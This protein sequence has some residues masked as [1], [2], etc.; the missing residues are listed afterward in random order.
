MEANEK[1]ITIPPLP[2]DGHPAPDHALPG[3]PPHCRVPARHDQRGPDRA[4]P[5]GPSRSARPYV[6]V[7]TSQRRRSGLG[8]QVIGDLPGHPQRERADRRPLSEPARPGADR[9]ITSRQARGA[10]AVSVTP[11]G[12]VMAVS[13]CS[14]G[15]IPGSEETRLNPV[16]CAMLTH[17]TTPWPRPSGQDQ[18]R[19]GPGTART[20]WPGLV[21]PGSAAR[22]TS[23]VTAAM[24]VTTLPSWR[25]GGARR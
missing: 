8:Q 15:Q 4:L 10:Y 12:R 25:A 21:R 19:P 6:P 2:R 22:D 9:A 24:P 14:A 20:G 13:R 18:E 16:F 7:T 23:I 5:P 11:T 17:P 1:V 3:L